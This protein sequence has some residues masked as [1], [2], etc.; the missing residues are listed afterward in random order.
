MAPEA[1]TQATEATEALTP[2]EPVVEGEEVSLLDNVCFVLCRPQGP[3]NIG[4]VARV[5]QNFGVKDLR[6]VT[7]EP[8]ALDPLA[9]ERR[10]DPAT[11]PLHEDAAKFAVHASWMLQDATR[12][13]TASEALADCTYVIATTAR[14]R[15][16]LPIMTA[17][18]AVAVIKNEAQRGKVAVLFGNEVRRCKLTLGS[19][20]SYFQSLILKRITVLP[21]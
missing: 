17:R 6:I 4:G 15:E 8:T 19:A 21:T 12:V 16:N 18:E 7:P 14:Q 9:V 11:A 20:A 10:A 2:P 13:A 3:Q 1:F 5:M